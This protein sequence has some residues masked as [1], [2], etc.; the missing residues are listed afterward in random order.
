MSRNGSVSFVWGDDEHEFRLGLGELRELQEKTG[1]SPFALCERLREGRPLVDDMR[2]VL[3]LGLI[4]GGLKPPEALAL[5][6][7]YADER[8][9]V[10]AVGPALVVLCAALYGV[11]DEAPG[12][13]TAETGEPP[14]P[15]TAA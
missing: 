9:L 5:V 8:P 14:A 2:E 3:R 10:G 12:K 15:P 11:A 6:R 13:S 1:V 7:F 4:G